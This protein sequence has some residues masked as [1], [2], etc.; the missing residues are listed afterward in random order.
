MP[1]ETV[2]LHEEW[3]RLFPFKHPD[4]LILDNRY[5]GKYLFKASYAKRPLLPS[6]MNYLLSWEYGRVWHRELGQYMRGRYLAE[7][8]KIF[9]PDVYARRKMLEKYMQ[10]IPPK[11]VV[12][13]T[14]YVKIVKKIDNRK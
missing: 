7:N 4:N 3:G 1:I 8:P 6:N 5:Y 12:R 10:R 2:K 14:K 13:S 9:K 11:P